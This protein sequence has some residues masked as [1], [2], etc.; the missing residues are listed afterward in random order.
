MAVAVAG[1]FVGNRLTKLL[2]ERIYV[3]VIEVALLLLSIRLVWEG[4]AAL[5]KM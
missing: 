4:A 3:A 5:W 1:T 2:P